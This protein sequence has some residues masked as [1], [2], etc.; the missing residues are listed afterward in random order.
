MITVKINLYK[1]SELCEVSKT[2]AIISHGEFLSSIPMEFE[3]EDGEMVEEYEEHSKK[4]IIES[5]EM[6][7]YIFFYN[8]N[9]APCTTY[10]GK[11]EKSGI[12]ELK[13]HGE[14]YEI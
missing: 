2:N 13:L 4:D 10:T 9:L 3:D 8:G 1:F 7:D 12:T 5:I 14:I 6:N 11:H